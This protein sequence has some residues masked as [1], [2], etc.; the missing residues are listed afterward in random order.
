MASLFS[1]YFNCIEF[2]FFPIQSAIPRKTYHC[3]IFC[4]DFFVVF[5]H[6]PCF[7]IAPWLKTTLLT[8]LTDTGTSS[9]SCAG[10]WKLSERIS[11]SV[12]MHP[13]CAVISREKML[14]SQRPTSTV[15]NFCFYP[16]SVDCRVTIGLLAAFLFHLD[17]TCSYTLLTAE[18]RAHSESH[19]TSP[20]FLGQH[21]RVAAFK[22]TYN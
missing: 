18:Q 11:A 6:R 5:L 1:L 14:Y 12:Y 10:N 17:L 7:H 22:A 15:D 16:R 2:D 13:K 20:Q 8:F 4:P 9:Y 3:Y 21:S 19:I